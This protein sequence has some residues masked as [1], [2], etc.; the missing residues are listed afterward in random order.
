ML[1]EHMYYITRPIRLSMVSI[2][3][4]FKMVDF[5]PLHQDCLIEN[6]F[7]GEDERCPCSSVKYP[8]EFINND[9]YTQ[10]PEALLQP[11]LHYVRYYTLSLSLSLSLTPP[12]I[13]R[14][15]V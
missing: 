8:T 1:H 2:L 13:G 14:A 10:L 15:H 9:T 7:L 6:P 3:P 11:P 5:D 12:Q 4:Y